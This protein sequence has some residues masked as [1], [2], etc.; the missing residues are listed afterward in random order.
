M[1]KQICGIV[2]LALCGAMAM[3]MAACSRPEAEQT[4]EIAGSL[5]TLYGEDGYPQA[6]LVAK[7]SVVEGDGAAVAEM[8]SYM[9]GADEYLEGTQPADIVSALAPTYEDGL[10]PSLNAKNL[11][12][13]VVKNCSVRFTAAADAKQA[14]KTFLDEL[15]AVDETFTSAP[16]DAFFY[17]GGAQAGEIAG[18]YSVYAPDGAPALAL[19]NAI[20]ETEGGAFSYHIVAASTIAARVT[21]ENPAADFCV[22]PVNA[23]AKVLGKGTSYCMLG[24]VTNGNM[25]FL[26][27][28]TSQKELNSAA[29]LRSLVGQTLGVVQL[30]NVPGLT[31]RVVLEREGVPYQILD[32]GKEPAEDKVNLVAFADASTVGPAAGCAY[33]LC[34]EPAAT[35]KS[36]QFKAQQAKGNA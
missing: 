12:A 28:N 2:S 9:E 22:L 5:Q 17:E 3:G 21:G 13:D 36:A 11:T 7:R 14:V 33:Y 26:R 8:I 32:S 18:S 35:A 24:V 31:L 34:P 1:K 25:Y 27:T 10:T 20:S 4:F 30:N 16:A 15:I 29:S 19:A 6:V 23:A